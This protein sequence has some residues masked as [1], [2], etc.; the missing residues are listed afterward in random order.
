MKKIVVLLLLMVST[1]VMAEWAFILNPP[2]NPQLI[3]DDQLE[4]SL[5]NICELRK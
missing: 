1:S 2:S 4:F 3:S 5:N